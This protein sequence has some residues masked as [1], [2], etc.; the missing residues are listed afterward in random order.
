[1]NVLVIIPARGGSKGIPRKNVRLLNGQPLISYAIRNA[2][3]SKY[4]TDVF[5]STDD[6]EIENVAMKYG[7]GIVKRNPELG[8]DQVTLDPVIDRK[9]VV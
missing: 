2:L 6:E 7:S 1:M 4:V 8:N 9:S 5:V 3:N